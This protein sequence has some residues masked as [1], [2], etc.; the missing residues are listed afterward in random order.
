MRLHRGLPARADGPVALT[1]GNF[2]GVHRGHQAMLLRLCEAAEDLRL[3]PAVLTFDPHPR[4]FFA[5]DSAP[6]RLTRLAQ[7][8]EVF[9][10]FGVARTYVAR[11]DAALAQL[12]AEAF[13]DEVLMRRLDARWVLVGEDFRFGKGRAG[14]LAV[15][16]E[17][18]KSFSVEAMHTVEV[19]GERASSSAVRAA[20]AAGEME[21]A[22]RLLGRHYT[23]SGRV[24]HGEKRGRTLGFPTANLPLSRMP[25]VSGIFVVRVHGLGDGPRDGVASVGVRPTITAHGKPVVE[26][27]LLD[28]AESIYGRRVRVEFLHKLRDE[29][30]YDD[31]DALV[32]Q[33]R[34]D[35]AQ[36]REYFA[37]AAAPAANA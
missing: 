37:T 19:D 10:A 11:F 15:L 13:I 1:I 3:V 36:T 9:R 21:R 8:L 31:L 32:T 23:I 6:P 33:I 7:K 5:R 30:K 4:E 29:A 2:D 24:A 27:Y 26:V 35:V 14:N 17:H 25:P 18:A 20:L 34:A 12:S 28:F 16:R 22:A